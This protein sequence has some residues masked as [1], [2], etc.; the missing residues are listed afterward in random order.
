MSLSRGVLQERGYR[1]AVGMGVVVWG[2]R[3]YGG[4]LNA[5]RHRMKMSLKTGGDGTGYCCWWMIKRVSFACGIVGGVCASYSSHHLEREKRGGG[6]E[7]EILIL[8]DSS[9]RSIWT[10][11]TAS[12][13]YTRERERERERSNSKTLILMDSS[14]RSIWTCLTASPYYTRERERGL[15]CKFSSLENFE[16]QTGQSIK[17]FKKTTTTKTTT[18]K[19]QQQNRKDISAINRNSAEIK[20]E[21]TRFIIHRQQIPYSGKWLDRGIREVH[22]NYTVMELGIF[23]VGRREKER[24]EKFVIITEWWNS[25][26]S[27]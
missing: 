25:A 22:N 4:G 5:Q 18:K 20:T 23:C 15:V 12:P 11:L 24:W 13:C 27:M 2:V 1:R 6:G 17:T 19:Q 3:G 16:N 8:L 9:V 26:L 21:P 14:V 10:Y 7:L